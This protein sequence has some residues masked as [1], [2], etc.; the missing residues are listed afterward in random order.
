MRIAGTF[1]KRCIVT[2][3]MYQ[4]GFAV[5]IELELMGRQIAVSMQ[6][7][8]EAAFLS[9]LSGT[10]DVVLY[11]SWSPRPESVTSFIQEDLASP[12]WV[13]N[14]AF[15]WQASF[16]RVDYYEKATGVPGSYFRLQTHGAPLLEY[17][18]HPI[19]APEPQVGGRLYWAKLFV[20]QPSEA[21]YDLAAF[22][23]WFTSIA[24]WVRKHGKKVRH[25]GTEPWCLPAARQSL[26]NEL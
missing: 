24:K 8:D 12:F 15:P 6:Q 19:H 5:Y 2:P 10:A 23:A 14:L 18:R 9:F 4:P 26:Q 1:L 11:R 17:S 20:S 3:R 25:G 21:A 22:D 7:E 13:H 16:E